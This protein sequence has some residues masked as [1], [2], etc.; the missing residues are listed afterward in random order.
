MG[1]WVWLGFYNVTGRYGGE[2][3]FL[4]VG[5]P[6]PSRR[7]FYPILDIGIFDFY[8]VI[9]TKVPRNDFP[10]SLFEML[11][12][13]SMDTKENGCQI[14]IYFKELNFNVSVYAQL[15]S[16]PTSSLPLRGNCIHLPHTE[17]VLPL[18]VS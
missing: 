6:S 7:S 5:D 11:V 9:H 12:Y 2:L 17:S 4:E 14:S 18:M 8:P 16:L 15:I 3:V 13:G 1:Q 10:L